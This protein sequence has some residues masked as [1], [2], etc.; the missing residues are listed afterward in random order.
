MRSWSAQRQMQTDFL[1]EQQ[2]QRRSVRH[3]LTKCHSITASMG[4]LMSAERKTKPPAPSNFEP[5]SFIFQTRLPAYLV[6]NQ[7]LSRSEYVSVTQRRPWITPIRL[8]ISGRISASSS[9]SRY[10]VPTAQT[11]MAGKIMRP[12]APSDD[13]HAQ[14]PYAHLW[15]VSRMS[16]PRIQTPTHTY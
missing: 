14:L 11:E 6:R 16:P 4:T 3:V 9:G 8:R 13:T 7:P 5:Q 12:E 2:L 1:P 10:P 15:F